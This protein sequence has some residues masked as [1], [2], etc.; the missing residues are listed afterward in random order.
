VVSPHRP[1]ADDAG[2]HLDHPVDRPGD[3][4]PLL[5]GDVRVD[6]YRKDRGRERLRD[7]AGCH[8]GVEGLPGERYWIVDGAAAKERRRR[9]AGITH[10]DDAGIHLDHPGTGRSA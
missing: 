2:V 7:R 3:V 6:R 1:R 9:H 10:P 4:C 8:P 5:V